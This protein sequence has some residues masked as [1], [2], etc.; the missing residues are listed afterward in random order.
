[1][2]IGIIAHDAH[3]L[4]EPYQGGLEMI[5][6]LFIQSLIQYGHHVT[7]LCLKGSETNAEQIY[8]LKRGDENNWSSSSDNLLENISNTTRVLTNFLTKDFDVIHNHSLHFLPIV[9]GNQLSIPFITTFHTPILKFIATAINGIALNVNQIFTA[10]S[11]SLA[12]EYKELLPDIIPIYNGIDCNYWK[13]SIDTFD[14]YYSWSGRIC[15][16]KG[17]RETIEFCEKNGLQLII[18]GPIFN[19]KYY[20]DEIKP[21]LKT[22]VYCK[23]IGHLNQR[24]LNH[25]VMNSKAFIFSS[26]WN[27]PYGLVIAEALACGVPVIAN[28]VGAAK[29]IIDDSCGTLFS[30]E[31]EASFL[32]S[33]EIAKFIPRDKCRYRAETFCSHFTMTERYLE[34]YKSLLKI[35]LSA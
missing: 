9:M 5:T 15:K 22:S 10:V 34:L 27:E 3:P 29:E 7:V 8:Y 18:A 32:R 24:D 2:K 28:N 35:K 33:V 19:E 14:N 11:D 30:L 23:Y 6:Y 25:L 4:R 12:K 26:T 31:N 16:E 20:N 17:L 1:M 21:R 13:Y